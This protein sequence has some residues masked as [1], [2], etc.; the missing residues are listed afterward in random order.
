MTQIA[1]NGLWRRHDW[2]PGHVTKGLTPCIDGISGTLINPHCHLRGHG[3]QSKVT[4]SERFSKN[5]TCLLPRKL[6]WTMENQPFEDVYFLFKNGDFPASHVSF[7]G[8]PRMILLILQALEWNQLLSPYICAHLHP[9]NLTVKAPENRP[10]PKRKGSET[11]QPSFF[12]GKLAVKFQGCRI[13]PS[14]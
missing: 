9:G 13:N 6:T 8:A 4:H 7:Q 5:E 11:F 12:R 2:I 1:L 3:S 10:H 14:T